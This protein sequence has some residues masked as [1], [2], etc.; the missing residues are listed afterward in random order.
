MTVITGEKEFFKNIPQIKYEGPESDNP[1]AFR[2]YDENKIVAG[3]TMKEYLRFAC[4]YWH[5]FLMEV[6]QILLVSLHIFFHG[7]KKQMQLKEQKI[8][9]MQHL[10]SSPK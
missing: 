8:K 9:W 6:V 7:M 2:W 3:K 10:N 1:F 4:A 5:S